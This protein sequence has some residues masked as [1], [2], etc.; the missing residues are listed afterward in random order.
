MAEP[1]VPIADFLELYDAAHGVIDHIRMHVDHAEYEGG[2]NAVER[3]RE[4]ATI[5]CQTHL[6]KTKRMKMAEKKMRHCWFC[7]AELG[8][9]GRAEWEPGD[10]CGAR[11]CEREA[12]NAA[13]EERREAHE[14][15]DRDMGW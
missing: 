10:T 11:E 1:T 3:F 15:L 6:P 8:V 9:L 7:G 14:Q 12:R 5:R 13:A 2:M 4:V